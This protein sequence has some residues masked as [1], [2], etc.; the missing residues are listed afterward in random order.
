M[1]T[2]TL[3]LLKEHKKFLIIQDF[4]CFNKKNYYPLNL[5]Q[6]FLIPRASPKTSTVLYRPVK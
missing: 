6:F 5:A 1:G 2:Y 4:I 3:L